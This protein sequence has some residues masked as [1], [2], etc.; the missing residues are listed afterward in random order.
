MISARKAG[1]KG[2]WN[3][4]FQSISPKNVVPYSN[5]TSIIPFV[6]E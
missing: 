1:N 6:S 2:K 3:G 4:W 5:F